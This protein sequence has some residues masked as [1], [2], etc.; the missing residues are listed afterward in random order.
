MKDSKYFTLC[1]RAISGEITP[2]EKCTLDKWLKSSPENRLFFEHI[3]TTWEKTKPPSLPYIQDT[4]QGWTML[5]KSLGLEIDKRKKK[6][7]FPELNNLVNN[8]AGLIRIR[9]RPAVFSLATIFILAIGLVFLK[10]QLSGVQLQEIVTLNKQ[11]TQITLSDGSQ[12]HLNNGSSIKFYKSFSDTLREVILTGEAFFKVTHDPRPFVV[13]TKN[14]RTTVLGTQFNVRAR[15]EQ[16]CVIVQEGFVMLSSITS[17]NGD[18]FLSEGQMS[19]ITGNMQP[20]A[21]QT[22]DAEYL[23]GWLEGKLVFER[24]PLNEIVSELERYYD[25][26]IEL[27]VAGLAQNTITASFE[28]SPL[29]PVLSSIC[30]TLGARY[31]FEADTYIITSE[32]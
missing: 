6:A 10:K 18:V 8:L 22:V 5:E 17:Y 32:Q 7:F 29:E 11:K 1:A 30:L 3:T 4:D 13:I 23:L 27:E 28:N 24:T 19:R 16:T 14:A 2:E 25:V 15:N 20:S 31:K 21:P 26:S 9:Y 12:V